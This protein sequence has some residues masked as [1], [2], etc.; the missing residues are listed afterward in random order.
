VQLVADA[1]TGAA[2]VADHLQ[3]GRA[4]GDVD[5]SLPP[6]PAERI[7]DEDGDLATGELADAVTD[8]LRGGIRIVREQDEH[9]RL[10]RI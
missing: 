9:L 6:R 1:V 7:G 8:G 5:R 3:P 10:R 4:E 2:Q